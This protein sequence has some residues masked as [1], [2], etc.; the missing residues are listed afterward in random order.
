MHHPNPLSIR[1]LHHILPP[2]PSVPTLL[3][4]RNPAQRCAHLQALE[5]RNRAWFP[6]ARRGLAVSHHQRAE[7][8]ARMRWGREDCADGGTVSGGVAGEGHA[9]ER[10][11]AVAAVE[12]FA[13]GPWCW[14]VLA[15]Y[16]ED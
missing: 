10:G 14:I 8:A 5:S 12:G 13:E 11:G 15:T 4:Q 9:Q 3:I 6:C 7:A 16:S 1:T 2:T